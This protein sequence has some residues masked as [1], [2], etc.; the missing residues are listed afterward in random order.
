MT[1]YGKLL[2]Q[3]EVAVR[4]VTEA[5]GPVMIRVGSVDRFFTYLQAAGIPMVSR[6]ELSGP[7]AF[8]GCPVLP[9]PRLPA[10]MVAVG[11]KL[12]ML[13]DPV[14]GRLGWIIDMARVEYFLGPLQ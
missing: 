2:K 10:D 1:T 4:L 11:D 12:M 3:L 9:D 13:P 5:P 14:A 7:D 8:F 6:G